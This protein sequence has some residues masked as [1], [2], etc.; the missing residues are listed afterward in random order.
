[1]L[2][3]SHRIIKSNKAENFED[4]RQERHAQ[5]YEE[6]SKPKPASS[7]AEIIEFQE[8]VAYGPVTR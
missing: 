8:N 1:M 2:F 5:L 7:S 6:V 4:H 3:I